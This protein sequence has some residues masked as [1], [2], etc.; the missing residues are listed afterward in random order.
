MEEY[1]AYSVRR[2]RMGSIRVALT[3]RPEPF[4]R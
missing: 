1:R 3:R 4:L 2:E